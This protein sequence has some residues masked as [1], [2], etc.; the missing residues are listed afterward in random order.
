MLQVEEEL[1]G[2]RT[3]RVKKVAFDPVGTALIN[4]CTFT[5]LLLL[6]TVGIDSARE[7]SLTKQNIELSPQA[8]QEAMQAYA[9]NM[10]K[11]RGEARAKEQSR[12]L[13]QKATEMVDSGGGFLECESAQSHLRLA[14]PAV[15]F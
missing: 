13:A 1:E 7:M 4:T 12:A 15:L 8:Q 2:K 14:F 6:T 9:D 10:E 11:Q 3:K 5:Q